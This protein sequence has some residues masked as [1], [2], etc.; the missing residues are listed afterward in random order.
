M[1]LLARAVEHPYIIARTN[2]VELLRKDPIAQRLS[3]AGSFIF[4]PSTTRHNS[5]RDRAR[6]RR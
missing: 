4:K 3:P 5:V 2:I 1:R 6:S